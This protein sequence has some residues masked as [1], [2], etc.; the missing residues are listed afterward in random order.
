MGRYMI[1]ATNVVVA[2]SQ[3]LIS[4]EGEKGE[5]WKDGEIQSNKSDRTR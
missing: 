2:V 4:D 3:L 5:R 1:T